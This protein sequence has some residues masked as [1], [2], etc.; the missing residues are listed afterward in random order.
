MNSILDPT[1]GAIFKNQYA[2][3]TTPALPDSIIELYGTVYGL[4][5]TTVPLYGSFYGAVQLYNM[6][7]TGVVPFSTTEMSGAS[8]TNRHWSVAYTE[9]FKMLMSFYDPAGGS[10]KS[11]YI[12][13]TNMAPGNS[14]TSVTKVA[15]ITDATLHVNYSTS[16]NLNSDHIYC[17]IQD[18]SASVFKVG[19][20][21]INALLLIK[22][23]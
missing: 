23:I 10:G 14:G 9:T 7:I 13:Y 12:D 19:V 15:T 3:Y 11:E 17:M 8:P 5:Y 16:D 2:N 18:H 20:I 22:F 1:T 21:N 6:G 4:H